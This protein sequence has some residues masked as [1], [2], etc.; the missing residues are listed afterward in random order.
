M[1]SSGPPPTSSLAY[2]RACARSLIGVEVPMHPDDR[3][4]IDQILDV[5]KQQKE[6]RDRNRSR[7]G[8]A[9]PLW[10]GFTNP[11]FLAVAGWCFGLLFGGL[12]GA[13]S[14]ALTFG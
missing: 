4:A 7:S 3:S 14:G 2:P 1:R 6:D 11:L 12:G 8:V 9:G 13:I 10:L 5:R